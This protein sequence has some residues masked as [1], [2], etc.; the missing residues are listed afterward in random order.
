MGNPKFMPFKEKKGLVNMRI[1]QNLLNKVTELANLK[2][3][4]LTEVI[5]SLIQDYMKDKIVTNNY[6]NSGVVFNIPTSEV[7]KEYYIQEEE[8]LR[9]LKDESIIIPNLKEV[10]VSTKTLEVKRVPNNLDVFIDDTFQSDDLLLKH[11][12]I[13]FY[14]EPEAIHHRRPFFKRREFL[15]NLY[16]FYFTISSVDKVSVYLIDYLEAINRLEGKDDTTKNKLISCVKELRKLSEELYEYG[17]IIWGDDEGEDC[18]KLEEEKDF[19]I[20]DEKLLE[21]ANKYNTDNIIEF[22][23]DIDERILF[24]N[25]DLYDESDEKFDE[26]K[27]VIELNEGLKKQVNSLNESVENLNTIKEII[28]FQKKEN[29]ELW[30]NIMR[31]L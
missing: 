9:K 17:N 26:I 16:C 24:S 7:T 2:N 18:F 25:I 20:F 28:E 31:K 3:I 30:E 8:D 12:G 14:I 23:S 22:G 10:M 13:D 19:S 5:T 11:E 4:T 27:R 6:L 29:P 15:N 1:N 21:I